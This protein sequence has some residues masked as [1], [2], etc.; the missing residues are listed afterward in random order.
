M[1]FTID[2]YYH[3]KDFIYPLAVSKY[4]EVEIKDVYEI[5]EKCVEY[6]I[7]NR[8]YGVYCHTCC[9]ITNYY[10][11]LISIP[12]NTFCERCDNEITKCFNKT[13]V[14]YKVR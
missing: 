13:V 3:S 7:I 5:L 12:N 10:D 8:I 2:E 11:N 1:P 9:H 4:T 14:I 6:K